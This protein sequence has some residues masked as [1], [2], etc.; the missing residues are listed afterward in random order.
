MLV[1]DPDVLVIHHLSLV[2]DERYAE[3]EAFLKKLR[4]TIKGLTIFGLLDLIGVVAPRIGEK[5]ARELY[6]SY[7]KSKEHIILF[8][9]YQDSWESH[10][11]TIIEYLARGLSYK[12]A[13]I[14]LVLDSTP[15]AEAY[16]TWRK[17]TLENKTTVKV[18]TP[19]EYLKITK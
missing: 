5:G 16:I 10:I 17:K 4:G 3:N 11:D 14:A 12:N 7:L 13:L 1:I 2:E 15:E 18:L 19:S 8:P 6:I 9:E